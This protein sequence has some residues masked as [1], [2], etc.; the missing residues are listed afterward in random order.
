MQDRGSGE[1]SVLT[2]GVPEACRRTSAKDCLGRYRLWKTITYREL[3]EQAQAVAEH[4]VAEGIQKEPVAI[5]LRADMNRL[6]QRWESLCLETYICQLVT[7]N[8]KREEN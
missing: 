7:T 5:T 3:K 2:Y 4:L 8:Q 1:S 6:L